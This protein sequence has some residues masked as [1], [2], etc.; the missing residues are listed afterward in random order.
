MSGD[1]ARSALQ[2]LLRATARRYRPAGLHAYFFALGKL[3]F[4]PIFTALL[5]DSFIPSGVRVLDLGCGQGLLFAWLL[6]ASDHYRAGCWPVAWPGPPQDLQLQGIERR[7]KECAFASIALNNR[8]TIASADLRDTSLPASDVVV[9][10]DVLHYL[11]AADQL[12]LLQRV[13]RCLSTQG[14]VLL[15]VADAGARLSLTLMTDRFGALLR[16]QPWPRYHVR[17]VAEWQRVLAGLGF[18]STTIPMSAGTPFSNV[19]IIA[20][21]KSE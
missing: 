5:R 2:S 17:P 16:G 7:Q 9:L 13:T 3:R 6:A 1:D 11:D 19:L 4:D 18:T 20:T 14:R 15:R 21:R 8:A 10:L 12:A